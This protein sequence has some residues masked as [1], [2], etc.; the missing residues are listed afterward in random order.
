MDRTG[1]AHEHEQ[2]REA[3]KRLQSNSDLQFVLTV[4]E[5]ECIH[6]LT[7]ENATPEQLVDANRRYNWLMSLKF[8]VNQ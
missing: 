4:L 5:K 3:C 1:Q 8:R 6:P 7:A 2:F